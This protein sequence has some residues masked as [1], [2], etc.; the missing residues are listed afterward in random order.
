MIG[1][2][3][4]SEFYYYMLNGNKRIE[5]RLYDDKRKNIKL[6][7]TIKFMLE[8]DRK[9]YFYAKVIGLLRYNSFND[10][11]N[12]IDISLVAPSRY[13]K[14]SFINELEKYYPKDKQL[15]YGII[16]IRIELL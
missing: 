8:P 6:G 1:M 15:K 2:G 7:D 12:D 3:L 14:N 4:Q 13:D 10:L 5:V 11:L 16:G 9:E